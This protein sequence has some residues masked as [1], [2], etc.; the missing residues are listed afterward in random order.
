MARRYSRTEKEKWTAPPPPPAKRPPVRIPNGDFEQLI[1]ANKLTIIGRVTNPNLQKP[2]SII[3]FMP[4]VWNLEGKVVGRDMGLEKFQFKFET[5]ADLL[6]VLENGPYHYKKWMLLLQR[7]EPSVS[8]DFPSNISFWI[9]IHGIP[10][11]LCSDGTIETVAKHLGFMANRDVNE[12]KIRVVI[13]GLLPLEMTMDIQLPTDE[14]I[15][16]EFEY[17]KIEKHCFTCFS[18][19]HEESDCPQRPRN[20][21]PLRDRKLGITQRI[22]LQRIEAE[23][24]RHD[25]RRG[26]RRP[27]DSRPSYRHGDDSRQVYRSERSERDEPHHRHRFDRRMETSPPNRASRSS[28]YYRQNDS[29][30]HYRRV[31]RSIQSPGSAG[32]HRSPIIGSGRLTDP[33]G[34]PI[35]ASETN[36]HRHQSPPSGGP[37]LL[38]DRLGS[39]SGK[40][41]NTGVNSKDRPSAL[42]R[43]SEIVPQRDEDTRVPP[44]FES[45]RLQE[46]EFIVEEDDLLDEEDNDLPAPPQDPPNRVSAAL[47]IGTAPK[48]DQRRKTRTIP[49]SPLS[50][51]AGK[52]RV[53][54]SQTNK[55]G[56]GSPRQGINLRKPTTTKSASVRKQLYPSS[57]KTLPCNK[58]GDTSK[59]TKTGTSNR[60]CIPGVTRG[61]VDFRPPS[62]PLP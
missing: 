51:A 61:G 1:E 31:E 9:R 25:E 59:K 53:V 40:A 10:L 41:V 45:G 58:D 48:T 16:I 54:R 47:R 50:K 2:R 42:D 23:K 57:T 11:H 14:V 56:A 17:I 30:R 34:I 6:K 7:W 49:I 60:V 32:S 24:I 62:N 26:Y 28:A 21:I 44:S 22:A 36:R 38:K 43:L 3:D 39:S 18:L 19:F 35:P 5:E 37:R 46:A 13:N 33:E 29:P 55:R 20:P 8:E 52:R 15:E 27:A 12:P 4:Q